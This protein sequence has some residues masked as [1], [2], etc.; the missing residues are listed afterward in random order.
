MV[1]MPLSK[2]KAGLKQGELVLGLTFYTIVATVVLTSLVFGP[3]PKNPIDVTGMLVAALLFACFPYWLERWVMKIPEWGDPL[4]ASVA[5][6]LKAQWLFLLV[7]IPVGVAFSYF[8][9]RVT[10]GGML[11][12]I[13][14][15]ILAGYSTMFF[16]FAG[17]LLCSLALLLL[18]QGV[19]WMVHHYLF[20][21]SSFLSMGV[22]LVIFNSFFLIAKG[23]ENARM[24]AESLSAKLEESNEKLRSYALRVGDLA[25]AEERNRLA[26]EIHDSIGHTLTVVNVQVEAARTVLNSDPDKARSAL[27]AAQAY[28]RQG[29]T[30]VREAVSSLRQSPLENKS[31]PQ[32]LE[33][34]LQKASTT[35]LK[36]NLK[37]N[38]TPL[39]L[40]AP[41]AHTLHRVAQETLTNTL[42]HAQAS[43]L[44]LQ[45]DFAQE[46]TVILKVKDNGKGYSPSEEPSG[47]GLLGLKER[48]G[49]HGGE[50]RIE[51]GEGSGFTL[52]VKLPLP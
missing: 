39:E 33:E 29:L 18:L 49:H 48:V 35:G 21:L 40:P 12:L 7:F 4:A 20:D 42:R 52:E 25:V 38:G 27:E 36:V 9:L 43:R 3:S 14:L 28:T 17:S 46:S 50:T 45:L 41:L 5:P 13:P 51:S 26:R 31:L 44:E 24:E 8:A 6:P 34:L 10:R 22:G 19:M 11:P 23:A 16:S 2:A 32:A 30:E 47:F 15:F 37:V 1:H